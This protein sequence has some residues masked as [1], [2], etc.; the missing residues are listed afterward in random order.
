MHPQPSGPKLRSDFLLQ[1]YAKLR[2]EIY[3]RTHV[4]TNLM[5]VAVLVAGAVLTV[6]TQ[7]SPKFGVPALQL[8][9]V[10]VM[11]LALAWSTQYAAIRTMGAF[12]ARLEREV[13]LG[14]EA[15]TYGWETTLSRHTGRHHRTAALFS[16]WLDAKGIFVGLQVLTMILALARSGISVGAFGHFGQDPS[17][18]RPYLWSLLLGVLD[19]GAVAVTLSLPDSHPALRRFSETW[20]KTGGDNA[21]ARGMVGDTLGQ[22]RP[23]KVDKTGDGWPRSR[24]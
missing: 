5:T 3:Q 24:E 15:G 22:F 11:F 20:A 19:L 14:E 6:G 16:G 4:L 12:I 9:P 7:A 2:E 23:A 21:H 17:I 1:Q 10:V 8:Y 18:L 13:F